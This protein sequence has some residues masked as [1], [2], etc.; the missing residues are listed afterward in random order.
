MRARHLAKGL[1]LGMLAAVEVHGQRAPARRVRVELQ[2]AQAQPVTGRVLLVFT[3]R[4]TSEPRLQIG[5]DN[6]PPVFGIDVTSLR[7][8]QTVTIDETVLGYPLTSLRDIPAGEYDVQAL[9]NVYTEFRR[10][11]GHVIWAH[12][13]QWEGQ[14]MGASPGNLHSEV[15]K[16]RVA[17]N[18]GFD[19]RVPIT[20]VIPPLPP[21]QDTKWLRY[22]KIQSKLLTAFWGRPVYLGATVLVP[23]GYDEHPETSYPVIYKQGHFGQVPFFF[24]DDPASA[25]RDRRLVEWGMQTGYDFHKSWDSDAF[26]RM[27]AV[28]IHHPTPFY[29]DSYAV[30]SANNGP[31]DDAIMQELLP[32]IETKYRII[33]KP[34]ARLL[35]GASTG[36][37]EA[38]AL[39][40]YHPDFYGGAWVHYPDPIDFRHYVLV[41]IYK[42]TNA[43]VAVS[44][45]NEWLLQERPW[46][47]TPEGQLATS[48]RQVSRLEEVLGPRGRSGYQL[49]GWESVF[50]PVGADGYPKPLWNKLTGTIDPSVADYMRDH[51][52]DLR[53]YAARNWSRIGPQLEGKIRIIVGDMDNYY[54]NLAVYQFEDFMKA[55]ANPHVEGMFTYGRPMKEHGW[56]AQNFADIVRDMAAAV[57]KNAPPGEDT[58]AW[59]Y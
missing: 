48:M 44:P 47:R 2:V 1:A 34:Y 6:T 7:S 24:N 49:H 53:E 59:L 14:R 10:S 5:G 8:G 3:R 16:V 57:R 42:D 41:D 13:D 26:P 56:H 19:V 12:M 37:W 27:I 17:A 21:Q 15:Q 9:L 43:F 28:T 38:L 22:L 54:L 4:T 55:T 33:R 40:L 39:Q 35:E 51:G 36:G 32:A 25:P 18:S 52:Y 58:K 30:N 11:D 31:Y 23:K 46:R 45:G 50:A 20:K 29:D